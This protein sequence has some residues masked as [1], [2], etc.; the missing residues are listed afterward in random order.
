MAKSDDIRRAPPKADRRSRPGSV[1][2]ADQARV[3]ILDAA[4]DCIVEYGW[5]GAN[6]SVICRRARI[7]RGR[8]QYYFPTMDDLARASIEYLNAEWRIRY[9][10]MIE[11][12]IDATER[13]DAGIEAVWRLMRD[14]LHV[15][16]QALDAN[17]R[18][19]P[20]L[21]ALMQQAVHTHEEASLEKVKRAYPALAR[22]GDQPIA[23]ARSFTMV[24]MEGLSLYRFDGDAEPHQ[25]ALIAMLKS[26]LLDYWRA[27]G[28]GDVDGVGATPVKNPPAAAPPSEHPGT[29][30]ALDLI[31]EAAEILA[32]DP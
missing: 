20:R 11:Q 8:M 17:A 10:E 9:F 12:I 3:A 28:L 7:T 14:P 18:T 27:R 26:M 24:F 6:M 31:R 22:L 2:K 21:N 30:R 23:L 25:E 5:E 1:S 32:D 4:V 13:F 16:K 15:A 29:R 19:N